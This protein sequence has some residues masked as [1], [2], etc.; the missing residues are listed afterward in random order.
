MLDADK[1]GL[2]LEESKRLAFLLKAL[3]CSADV[4]NAISAA[5]R[6]RQYVETGKDPDL[7]G[8]GSDAD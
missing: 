5:E 1:L 4:G 6:M 7:A 2:S 3:D 8:S